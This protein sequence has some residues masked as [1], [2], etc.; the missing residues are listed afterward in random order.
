MTPR[1]AW[2]RATV[3][4]LASAVLL[5]L[6]TGGAFHRLYLDRSGLPDLE[7]LVRF[8]PPE[9]RV[10]GHVYDATGAVLVELATEYRLIV[11][12]EEIPPVVRH[13]ILAAEDKRFFSHRGVDYVALRRAALKNLLHLSSHRSEQG[14]SL[15]TLFPQGASTLTQQLVRGYY[16]GDFTRREDGPV[17][18]SSGVAA[19]LAAR[20]AGIPAANKLHR[21][22]EEIRLA[23][24]VEDEL[25]REFGS[26]R[27][28]K[29]EILARYAS[30][31]YLGNGRYGFAA[32]AEYYFGRPLAGFGPED[33]AEAALLTGIVRSP[34]RYAPGSADPEESVR[35]RN[36]VLALMAQN[37]FL[38]EEA[39]QRLARAPLRLAPHRD[40][41]TEAPAVVEQV[42][43]ELPRRAEGRRLEDLFDGTLQIH[44]TA[45][46]RVQRI[47]NGALER[48]LARYE[49]RHAARRGEIQG[50]VVVLK[51]RDAAI[52]AEAGGRQVYGGRRGAYS[53][54]N[55]ASR[56]LRQPGS[57]MKPV[58]YLAAFR[59]GLLDLDTLVPDI[60]VRVPMGRYQPGKWIANYDGKYKGMIPARQALAESRNAAA[61]WTARRA[62]MASVL[63]AARDLGIETPL[64]PYL[65]TALGASEVTLVELAGAYRAMASGLAAE[66]HAMA[67]I[68]G[69]SGGLRLTRFNAPLRPPAVR[70]LA[71]EERALLQIQEGLRGVVRMPSGT[72]HALDG[73]SLG[74]AV[75]GKTGTTND[76]R[77][78]LF[79]G[80]TYGAEGITVAVR[81]AFDDNAPLGDRES[82]ARAALPIFREIVSE[83]YRAGLVGPAPA[84]PEALER[85]IES[86]LA[87]ASLQERRR[88]AVV[89]PPAAVPDAEPPGAAAPSA[90]HAQGSRGARR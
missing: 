56:S 13:A 27:L 73:K 69:A 89:A 49:E 87:R 58:V 76:F 6:L 59:Q 55:R 33:A 53:D 22:F 68:T 67:R 15:R 70:P 17:L 2:K 10:T 61:V 32:A 26:K 24:W 31:V 86:H 90:A 34:S 40:L 50:A 74:V 9:P 25:E 37:G 47:V 39:A 35:R 65:T 12:P 43:R 84:F 30:F 38:T 85:R 45:D 79:V 78:A 75:M 54:L 1:A 83:I 19:R 64:V 42:L 51:N 7:H 62:G 23:L 4:A 52:L 71:V 81:V 28:A 8:E 60:P 77:D 14:Q 72:A 44:A 66:P 16:L 5:L 80:S 82:G 88:V 11:H 20:V 18:L 41:K 36:Q 21:K 46:L 3:A 63:E 29:E 57:A 48:G